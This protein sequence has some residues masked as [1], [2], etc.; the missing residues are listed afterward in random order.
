V[1]AGYRELAER[2]PERVRLVPGEGTVE[3]VHARVMD[4]VQPLL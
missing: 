1:A 3:E 4:A 2:F